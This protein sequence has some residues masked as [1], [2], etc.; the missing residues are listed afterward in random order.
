L[1]LNSLCHIV[2]LIIIYQGNNSDGQIGISQPIETDEL[3]LSDMSF[4]L[5]SEQITHLVCA[6]YYTVCVLDQQRVFVSGFNGVGQL[7]TGDVTSVDHFVELNYSFLEQEGVLDVQCGPAHTLVLT[8]MNNLYMCGWND[9]GE[10]GID[11]TEETFHTLFQVKPSESGLVSRL[12]TSP[13]SN[14]TTV[15]TDTNE[16][17]ACGINSDYESCIYSNG[18]TNVRQFTKIEID[19]VPKQRDIICFG[20]TKFT[21]IICNDTVWLSNSTK[22]HKAHVPYDPQSEYISMYSASSDF[23]YL[24]IESNNSIQLH[25][26]NLHKR[27]EDTKFSDIT[28]LI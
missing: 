3:I 9:K 7:G 5:Q 21:F 28:I 22:V 2:P 20:G 15:L 23:G 25:F 4:K 11:S 17:Y 19:D 6:Y 1:L 26:K 10:L 8:K 27:L 12:L 16:I 13:R 18:P 24:I 14:R